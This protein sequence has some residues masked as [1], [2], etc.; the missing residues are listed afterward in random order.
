MSWADVQ[1]HDGQFVPWKQTTAAAEPYEKFGK[2]TALR[3]KWP[4]HA[5]SINHVNC[6]LWWQRSPAKVSNNIFFNLLSPVISLL[7][8]LDLNQSY[9]P[10]HARSNLCKSNQSHETLFQDID[11]WPPE[12]ERFNL[13]PKHLTLVFKEI[14]RDLLNRWL[15][16]V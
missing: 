5:N 1:S 8:T 9:A 2:T 14:T 13:N 15:A 7:L 4:K 10:Q 11:F 12:V 16:L 6:Q 3:Q